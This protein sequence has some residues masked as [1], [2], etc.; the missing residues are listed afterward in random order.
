M[1]NK[2]FGR[3]INP[4]LFRA[5]VATTIATEDPEHV[6]ASARILGHTWI[7]TTEQ[8][9]NKAK[10]TEA[11]ERFHEVLHELKNDP[12]DDEEKEQ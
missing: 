10:M 6:L 2:L 4:H 8:S 11:M 7:D 1:T 5:C 12:I 3:P 9:Y